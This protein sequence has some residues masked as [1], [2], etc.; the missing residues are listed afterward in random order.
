MQLIR[1]YIIGTRIII[2]QAN[3]H[4]LDELSP[5]ALPVQLKDP[6]PENIEKRGE[7]IGELYESQIPVIRLEDGT[8]LTGGDCWWREE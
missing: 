8:V 7:I 6:T 1:R 3:G 4:T 2:V 5:G